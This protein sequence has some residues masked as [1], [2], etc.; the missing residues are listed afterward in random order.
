MRTPKFRL[1]FC[2]CLMALSCGLTLLVAGCGSGNP[3][4]TEF[5]NSAPPGT[6]PENPDETVSQRRERTRSK[7][8]KEMAEAKN[9]GTAAKGP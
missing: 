6:P 9:K 8:K 1:L 7:T 4:E 3:N 5:L 2:D